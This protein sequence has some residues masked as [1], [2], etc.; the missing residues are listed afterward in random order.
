MRPLL[1]AA[2]A[3]RVVAA[4]Y[5]VS[6]QNFPNPERGFFV[7]TAYNPE[8]KPGPLSAAV[9]ARA[10]EHGMS[11]LRMS[12]VL[13]EFRDRPLSPAMLDRIRA[14]CATARAAGVKIIA[15]FNYNQGPV[16]EPDA[17]LEIVLGHIDQLRPVLRENSDVLA[18]LEAGF[19]GTWGEWHHSTNGL[20]DHTREVVEKLLGALPPDR[21]I[22][23]RYPRAKTELYGSAPLTSA[24]DFDGTPCAR[25]GAHNDC[26][27]ASRTDR[28]TWTMSNMASEKAFYHADN[29]FVPQGGETC[30]TQADG[31][32]LIS[33]ENALRELVYQRFNTL[34]SGF[35]QEVLTGWETSGCMPEIQRR[36]GY[37]FRLMES[38]LEV[39]AR[40]IPPAAPAIMPARDPSRETASTGTVA[41]ATV[42][43]RNDGFG[44]LYNPRPVFLIARDRATGRMTR[45]A[46]PTD[47]RR[48]MPDET[49]TI[50]TDIT[51][52][53]GEYDL[54][55][56]L[57]DAS[58]ALRTRSEYSVRFAN[59]DVWEP[60]T[61]M[62]RLAE[63]VTIAR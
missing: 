39:V 63:R 37:R 2:I 61:G 8:R 19:I 7:Q 14:D 23:L 12:W 5:P 3:I 44:N 22:A 57:P 36:L 30:Q 13:S 50:H 20:T 53:P 9:L 26:F 32:P 6:D 28:G 42:T 41:R 52:P 54:L 1:I 33:C 40:A 25:I 29:L 48:W 46:I 47:P 45:Q 59:P 31:R 56:H 38:S 60:A 10:R 27:L 16:G 18:F 55:L 4:T 34:N 17:P 11:L 43:L 15:R 58:E 35:N 24:E 21:M 51:L 49:T 62:N